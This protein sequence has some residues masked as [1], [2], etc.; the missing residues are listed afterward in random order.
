MLPVPI[1]SEGTG[2][3]D[4]LVET[5]ELIETPSVKWMHVL[6]LLRIKTCKCEDCHILRH[7]LC[8]PF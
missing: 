5:W 3:I 7:Q 2:I 4:G 8:I 6:I 1:F